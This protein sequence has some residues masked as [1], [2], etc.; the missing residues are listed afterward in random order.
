V[1]CNARANSAEL[2]NRGNCQKDNP[3]FLTRGAVRVFSFL[4]RFLL[5]HG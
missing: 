5:E 2:P 3:T 1:Y 4:S